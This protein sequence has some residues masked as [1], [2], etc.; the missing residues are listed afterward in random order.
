V[1]LRS[2]LRLALAALVIGAGV[3]HFTSAAFFVSIV[4]PWLP[5]PTVL[6]QISGVAEIAGG[7]GIVLPPTRR[8]A[9]IGLMLLFFAVFPANVNMALYHLPMNGKAVA[10]ALL[11]ARLFLQPLLIYWAWAC[12]VRRRSPATPRDK[13]TRLAV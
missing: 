10:P 5:A 6:V 2:L 8:A 1:K 3:M 7:L 11:W 12:A 4:P 9:G 13:W